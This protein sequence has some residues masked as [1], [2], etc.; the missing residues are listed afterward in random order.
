MY[1]YLCCLFLK[2]CSREYEVMSTN[3]FEQKESQEFVIRNTGER[4][5]TNITLRE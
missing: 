2:F 5:N 4:E 1:L 3:N